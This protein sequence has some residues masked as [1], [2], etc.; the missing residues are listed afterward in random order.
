MAGL[1]LFFCT[2][3]KVGLD[4]FFR[5]LKLFNFPSQG[6]VGL[7]EGWWTSLHSAVPEER[8]KWD[9]RNPRMNEMCTIFSL[10][11]LGPPACIRV[12]W[13]RNSR[14]EHLMPLNPAAPGMPHLQG[15]TVW[16]LWIRSISLNIESKAFLKRGDNSLRVPFHQSQRSKNPPQMVVAWG[17]LHAAFSHQWQIYF[18]G[19]RLCNRVQRRLRIPIVGLH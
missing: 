5:S 18:K 19:L 1:I 12:P 9:F 7:L 15:N 13:R 14:V 16:F 11:P 2:C 17:K 3:C 6:N 8:A 10:D 4:D